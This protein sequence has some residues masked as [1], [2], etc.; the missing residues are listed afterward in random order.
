[1]RDLAQREDDFGGVVDVRVVVVLE[2]ERPAARLQVRAPLHPVSD[3]AHFLADQP[4]RGSNHRGVVGRESGIAERDG[5]ERG[6]PD[7]RLA[8]FDAARAVFDDRESV[9]ACECLRDHG[10][11]HR[12]AEY[13]ERHHRVHPGR[14]DSAP[15]PVGFLSPHDPLDGAPVGV[16]AQSPVGPPLVELERAVELLEAPLPGRDRMA[17]RWRRVAAQLVDPETDRP[18]WFVRCDDRE[19]HDRLP[20]PAAEVVDVQR[21]PVRKQDHLGG[22]RGQVVPRPQPEQRHPQPRENARALQAAEVANQLRGALHVGGVRGVSGEPQ[23]DVGLGGG[24][25][26]RRPLEEVC[27]GSVAALLAADPLRALLGLIFAADAEELA[28]HQIFRVD[29]DVRVE[30]TLPPAG[31]ALQRQQVSLR[32]RDGVERSLFDI[33]ND[34]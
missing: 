24:R 29:R 6:V 14:L 11:I 7:R 28:Q 13:V 34:L 9:E 8:G 15:A 27:P 31:F 19:R 1:V 5:R 25:E 17:R 3:R 23:R 33:C 10:V 22:H 2:L 30:C 16:L 18:N 20:R 32:A 21:N 26:L 12:V 4:V